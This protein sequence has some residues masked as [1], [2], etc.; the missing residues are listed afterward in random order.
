MGESKHR[1]ARRVI[2]SLSIQVSLGACGS[3]PPTAAD[4]GA[5]GIGGGDTL[6]TT[7]DE[8]VTDGDTEGVDSLPDLGGA[9]DGVGP[10]EACADEPP[11]P[12]VIPT[13]PSCETEPQIGMF[14]PVVEWTKYEWT[15]TP[16][17]RSSVTTPI[18]AQI[19]DDDGNGVID[20]DDM[21]DI[22]FVTYEAGGILR[23]VSGDGSAEILS[24]PVAGFTRET[25]IAAADIDNDGI[26]E[27]LGI[28]SSKRVVVHEHDGTH[29]WTSAALTGHV[30]AYDNG[31]AISDMNGDGVPEIIAGRA[32]LDAAGNLIA[33]GEHGTGSASGNNSLSLSFAVDVDGDGQQEVVVGNALY[34]MDGSTI[35]FN[36]QP[37]GFPAVADFDL[38]GTPEIVVVWNNNIRL[39]SSVDGSVLWTT[40]VPGGNGGPPT[41]ADYDGDGLPEIGIAGTS[42]YTVWEGD[43]LQLWSN[44]TQDASSGITGSAVFDFEGDGVADVV[45]ADETRLWVYAGHDGTVKL[46]FTEHSSGTRVEYPIIADV[47]GDDEV[48]IAYVNEAYNGGLRGL[49]VIGDANHSWQPGRKIWNQ[50]AYH[51]T[52]ID[53]DGGVPIA[54]ASNWESFNNFRSGQMG[55]NDGLKI[56]GVE[57]FVQEP[58]D[59]GCAEGLRRVY[60]QIGNGG[61]G[62]LSTAVEVEVYG[63]T[64]GGDEVLIDV[65]VFDPPLLAGETTAGLWV[66]VDPTLYESVRGQ[67][68][69]IEL[70]CNATIADV[71][72]AVP[73]CPEWPPPAG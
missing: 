22:M 61:A 1:A 60:F 64:P 70:V 26:V 2:V 12:F 55:P 25:T 53:D 66:D 52:N 10:P 65:L 28:D 5:T 4:D 73:P 38:D 39:Q 49:T 43:G 19:T 44:P 72:V 20:N 15:D 46:E 48:E 3:D 17:S 11:A 18:V 29:K 57:L 34:R 51:I 16:T 36:G 27:I 62:S 30:A 50:H 54:A 21:P 24:V 33:A 23:A 35:W 45:Y 63:V 47:D 56:P 37:D 67:A 58:C 32:I 71:D 31:T 59:Q 6:G 7:G 14:T 42:T 69:A 41:V 68:E 40:A 13:D 9:D 8:V